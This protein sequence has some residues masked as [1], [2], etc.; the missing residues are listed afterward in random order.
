MN[1]HHTKAAG[2][3]CPK[4]DFCRRCELHVI[5]KSQNQCHPSINSMI[6]VF[7]DSDLTSQDTYIKALWQLKVLSDIA[8]F[9]QR[10][11]MT[12]SQVSKNEL[13]KLHIFSNLEITCTPNKNFFLDV[14]EVHWIEYYLD[15]RR[16]LR[17]K[18][19]SI[20]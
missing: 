18:F 7:T 8:R 5:T 16:K 20:W 2:I 4:L 11:L 1:F 15:G 19:K 14:V 10:Y 3:L 17:K 13:L 6:W 9:R 12:K